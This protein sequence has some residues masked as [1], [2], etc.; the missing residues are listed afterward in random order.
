[1]TEPDIREW[2]EKLLRIPGAQL[3][4]SEE[5]K[6]FREIISKLPPMS[7]NAPSIYVAPIMNKSLYSAAVE[8][9]TITQLLYYKNNSILQ[10]GGF[11]DIECFYFHYLISMNSRVIH[12]LDNTL[13]AYLNLAIDNLPLNMYMTTTEANKRLLALGAIPFCTAVAG[14]IVPVDHIWA[15]LV[16]AGI[17]NQD[18]PPQ[19]VD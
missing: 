11:E 3:R 9:E 15:A 12:K 6:E 13:Y 16:M 2:V 5:L 8:K 19:N 14:D 1:M 17:T 10:F 4:E 7:R 18:T